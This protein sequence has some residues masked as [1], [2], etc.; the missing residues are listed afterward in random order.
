MTLGTHKIAL[1]EELDGF[2]QQGLF[3]SE[4][5]ITTPQQVRVDVAGQTLVN[6]CAN[7]YLGLAQHPEV[8]QAAHEGL[9]NW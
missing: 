6:F 5:V 7:N 4:R 3:K 8:I 9:D 1:Q 2:R